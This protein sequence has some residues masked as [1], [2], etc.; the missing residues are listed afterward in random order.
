VKNRWLSSALTLLIFGGMASWGTLP[1]AAQQAPRVNPG[2]A[3]ID[4]SIIFKN[5]E[6]FKAESEIMKQEV[7]RRENEFKGQRD[8]LRGEAEKLGQYRAGSPEFKKLEADLTQWTAK[9]QA[10]VNIQKKEF[11]DR[12]AKI[13]FNTYREILDEVK[14]FSEQNGIVLVMRFSSEEIDQNP[15]A[16][17][18][19][20]ELNKSVV[21]HNP[22]IDI[23]SIILHNLN[24]RALR[25]GGGA[26]AP[27]VGLQPNTRPLPGQ[28]APPRK[29]Q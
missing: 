10:D 22:A 9:L 26:P 8:A 3:I 1:A 11:L 12:E 5:H 23:S 7:M 16:E 24:N 13:Y 15:D 21:Y 17:R 2:L 28:F 19:M 14:Y 18:V 27:A 4:L 20:K 25:Q 6:R 29:L